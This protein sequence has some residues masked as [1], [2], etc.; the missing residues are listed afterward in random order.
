MCVIT[1][2]IASRPDPVSVCVYVCVWLYGVCVCVSLQPASHLALTQSLCV[3]VCV[4]ACSCA[5]ECECACACACACACVCVCVSV[6]CGHSQLCLPPCPS[7]CVLF[8]L[9]L[10]LHSSLPL[11]RGGEERGEGG[12]IAGVD[13]SNKHP[14]L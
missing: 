10:V 9:Q 5:C 14:S 1:A 11:S 7:L 4:C 3:C 2:S 8:P 13:R 6:C 12:A